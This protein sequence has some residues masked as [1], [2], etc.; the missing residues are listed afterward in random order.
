MD[1][2]LKELI[3]EALREDVGRG[4]VTSEFLFEEDFTAGAVL[5]AKENGIICGI[6][7]FKS[8]FLQLSPHFR[9][10]FWFRDGDRVNRK[11]L[12]AEITGPVREMMAGERTALNFIQHLSGIATL[13]GQFVKKSGKVEVFDTRKTNP[14]L[15]TETSVKTGGE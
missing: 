8:V 5:T 2:D 9:F 14:L 7:V 6:G 15:K 11:D 12:V 13:T 1:R 3:K 4:D 10:R